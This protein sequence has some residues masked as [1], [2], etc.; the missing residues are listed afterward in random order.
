[1]VASHGNARR[2]S[3]MDAS[4]RST[5]ATTKRH[6]ASAETVA[7]LSHVMAGGRAGQII[8]NR[9]GD[10]VWTPQRTAIDAN[11]ADV[12]MCFAPLGWA[13]GQSGDV[14]RT[15]NGGEY[16]KHHKTDVGY[17]LNAVTF[18][19]KLGGWALRHRP[20]HDRWRI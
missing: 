10:P 14:L 3:E 2:R 18:I 8:H 1:M 6:G 5:S 7:F 13:V 9:D 15:I 20:A 11:L 16:W 17:D 19:A 12:E 4:A